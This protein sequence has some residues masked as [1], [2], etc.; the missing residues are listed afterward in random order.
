LGNGNNSVTDSGSGHNSITLGTGYN[1]LDLGSQGTD[2]VKIGANANYNTDNVTANAVIRNATSGNTI[3]F[4]QTLAQ[5]TLENHAVAD[6]TTLIHDLETD[7]HGNPRSA[8]AQA[9]GG[10]T[11]IVY[12]NSGTLGPTDTAIVELIGVHGINISGSQIVLSS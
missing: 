10:N 1:T 12:S 5:Y 3:E 8:A 11:Y 9:F 2:I 7:V 6:V 4:A